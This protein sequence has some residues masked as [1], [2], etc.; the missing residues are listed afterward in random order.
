MSV[1]YLTPEWADLLTTALGAD[2]LIRVYAR[3]QDTLF[4]MSIVG[5]PGGLAGYYLHI[6]EGT[7]SFPQEVSRSPDVEASMDYPDAVQLFKGEL[8]GGVALA[9]GKI[10]I[11]QDPPG[12]VDRAIRAGNALSRIPLV[13]QS[14]DITY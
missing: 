3:E 2:P 4:H 8:D 10:R 5:A 13:A 12:G 7:V 14:L 1:Q 9:T 6:N 11:A